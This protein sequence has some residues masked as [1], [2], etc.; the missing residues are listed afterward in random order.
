MAWSAPGPLGAV[1]RFMAS[2]VSAPGRVLYMRVTC[3]AWPEFMPTVV[4]QRLLTTVGRRAW[5]STGVGIQLLAWPNRPSA[6]VPRRRSDVA[7]ADAAPGGAS[8]PARPRR[9]AR[10]VPRSSPRPGSGSR[11]TGTSARRSAPSRRMPAS[12]PRWSCATT[13]TRK[14][15][16]PRRPMSSCSSPTSRHP[17]RRRRR[18]ARRAL[19]RP[20]GERTS[21]RPL[22]RVGV[23]NE[24]GAERMRGVFAGQILP[25]AA[26]RRDQEDAD[27][28]RARRL[29]GARHGA[30]AV[31]AEVR[32]RRGPVRA[33]S[34][35][36][37]PP[38]S[39]AT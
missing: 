21:R 15:C 29:P 7:P 10:P 32:P 9:S 4:C 31:R 38:P 25:L 26:V 14:A 36:G 11:Q 20:V 2:M 3:R 27:P 23:T 16:S 12:T 39:S 37:W 22:L 17:A 19:P 5:R 35:P 6:A 24:A 30:R 34:S 33:R 28:R 8:D 1:L 18:P 13:A